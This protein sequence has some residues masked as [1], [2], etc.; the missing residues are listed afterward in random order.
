MK[1]YSPR[2]HCSPLERWRISRRRK[3]LSNYGQTIHTQTAGRN[4]KAKSPLES[5]CPLRAT[6]I[7]EAALRHTGERLIR[8]LSFQILSLGKEASIE[9]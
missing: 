2:P 3:W 5:R 9:E 8:D 1:L 7:M 4:I 6:L